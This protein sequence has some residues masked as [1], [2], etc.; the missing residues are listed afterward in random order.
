MRAKQFMYICAG[1][2]I[3]TLALQGIDRFAAAQ[4]PELLFVEERDPGCQIAVDT[5]GRIYARGITLVWHHVGQL[6]AGTPASF[7]GA[8]IDGI[9]PIHLTFVIGMK[10]GDVWR[11]FVPDCNNWSLTTFEFVGN[12]LSGTVAAEGTTITEVKN[13]FREEE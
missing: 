13:K 12:A 9:S 7:A 3:L 5:A 6:P 11:M 4:A 8:S 2:L 10:N 1:I